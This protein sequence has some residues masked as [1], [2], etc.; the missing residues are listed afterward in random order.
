M[1]TV[2]FLNYVTFSLGSLS[3]KSGIGLS[4]GLKSMGLA[5]MDLS[6]PPCKVRPP[7]QR[8][9]ILSTCLVEVR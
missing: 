6:S 5:S 4:I 9:G 8:W 1:K 2:Q 7:A 3:L